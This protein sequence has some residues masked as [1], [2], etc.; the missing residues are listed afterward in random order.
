MPSAGSTTVVLVAGA[1]APRLPVLPLLNAC[2]QAVRVGKQSNRLRG[3]IIAL[4]RTSALIAPLLLYGNVKS[5]HAFK[6]LTCPTGSVTLN[7]AVD[8]ANVPV[9]A[10]VSGAAAAANCGMCLS[11]KVEPTGRFVPVTVTLTGLVVPPGSVTSAV[12]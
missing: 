3:G 9:D 2:P 12:E 7:V 1:K 5:L 8:V 4:H 6:T 11:V 10:A